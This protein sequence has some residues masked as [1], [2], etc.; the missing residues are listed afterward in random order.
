M[1][2]WNGHHLDLHVLKHSVPTRRS[3]DLPVGGGRLFIGT[4]AA[5]Q[6][7]C[8]DRDD[9][10]PR[11][12]AARVVS[13]RVPSLPL[14]RPRT[15]RVLLLGAPRTFAARTPCLRTIGTRPSAP[16]TLGAAHAQLCVGD[17]Q[18]TVAQADNLGWRLRL[19]SGIPPLM[20]SRRAR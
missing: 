5:R 9:L 19:Y 7:H 17:D 15:I 10:R 16:R 1:L 4:P 8:G 11:S 3:S 20:A 13:A 6:G 14:S 12:P 2:S 18:W